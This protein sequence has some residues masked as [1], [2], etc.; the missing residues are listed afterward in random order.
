MNQANHQHRLQNQIASERKQSSV[1][2][3][4]K[5]MLFTNIETKKFINV[6]DRNISS[7]IISQF[8]DFYLTLPRNTNILQVLLH[9]FGVLRKYDIR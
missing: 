3:G 6:L 1:F 7:Q 8:Y 9:K 5:R 2:G 4:I